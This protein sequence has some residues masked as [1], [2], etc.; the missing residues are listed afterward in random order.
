MDKKQIDVVI[1][2]KDAMERVIRRAHTCDQEVWWNAWQAD[3][4]DSDL[5]LSRSMVNIA[6]QNG[7]TFD[8]AMGL[9][10]QEQ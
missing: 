10:P 2:D 9:T 1:T 3:G 4:W 6:I 5:D 7:L 8:E